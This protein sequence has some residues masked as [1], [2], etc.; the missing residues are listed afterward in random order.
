MHFYRIFLSII[1]I[2]FFGLSVNAQSKPIN[3]YIEHDG[4]Q[5]SKPKYNKGSEEKDALMTEAKSD[6]ELTSSEQ[7]KKAKAEE[8]RI[9]FSFAVLQR[10]LTTTSVTGLPVANAIS[11]DCTDE[12]HCRIYFSSSFSGMRPSISEAKKYGEVHVIASSREDN[13]TYIPDWNGKMTPGAVLIIHNGTTR[14]INIS[15]HTGIDK[16]LDLLPDFVD[17]FKTDK[18]AKDGAAKSNA[19]ATTRSKAKAV[20]SDMIDDAIVDENEL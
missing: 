18:A 15:T 7:K 3:Y 16:I 11:T 5:K 6:R 1:L 20:L 13:Y 14:L 17:R 10:S 8:N 12:S 2:F 19:D 4:E 9:C